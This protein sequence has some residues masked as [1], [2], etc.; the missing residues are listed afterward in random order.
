MIL[1]WMFPIR[2]KLTV[3]LGIGTPMIFESTDP[4]Q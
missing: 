4:L 1:E 3:F 2:H